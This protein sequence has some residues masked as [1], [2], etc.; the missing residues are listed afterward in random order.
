[1][2]DQAAT[3]SV[4]SAAR[5]LGVSRNAAYESISRGEFP[6]PILRCGRRILVPKLP[7][8]EALGLNSEPNGQADEPPA[9]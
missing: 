2:A 3:L 6:V 9:K 5:L 8:F 7:L 4:E 1:M